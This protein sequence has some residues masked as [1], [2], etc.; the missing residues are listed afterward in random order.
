MIDMCGSLRTA[1][2]LATVARALREVKTAIS[3]AWCA[4]RE[5][6]RHLDLALQNG[7][8]LRGVSG[9]RCR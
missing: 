9:M 5:P 8:L 1:E 3:N 7:G 2:R 6:E 4:A